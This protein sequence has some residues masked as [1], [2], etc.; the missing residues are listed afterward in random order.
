MIREAGVKSCGKVLYLSEIYEVRG[1]EAL[2][3]L[4]PPKVVTRPVYFSISG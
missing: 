4:G 2:D 3:G 1:H